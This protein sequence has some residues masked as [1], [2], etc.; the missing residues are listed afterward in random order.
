M[1]S[2]K[3]LTASIVV[4]GIIFSIPIAIAQTAPAP[5]GGRGPI[6]DQEVYHPPEAF[7]LKAD[8]KAQED[9]T[10]QGTITF[11]NRGEEILGDM[12]YLIELLGELPAATSEDPVV[13][14]NAPVYDTVTS[15][16]R[17]A[18][19]GDEQKT[20]PYTYTPP[21]NLPSGNYRIEI[22][23]SN[24]RGRTLGWYDVP[25]TLTNEKGSFAKLFPG[26]IS[27]AE[28]GTQ[29]FGAESGPNV[30][31]GKNITITGSA[32]SLTTKSVVPELTIHAFSP[33]RPLLRTVKGS[34]MSLGTEDR[35]FSLSVP[36]SQE[37]G[38]YIGILSL[39]DVATNEP[40]SNLTT[41]R[42]VVRGQ[43][44]DILHVRMKS[45][46]YAQNDTMSF[47]IDHVGAA[48][49]ETKTTGKISMELRDDEG[50]LGTLT[51]P[52]AELDDRI[53][54]GEANFTLGR[55]LSGQAVLD[56]KVTKND[57]YPLTSY[58][59]RYPFTS[60]QLKTLE[61]S[62]IFSHILLYAGAAIALV[63][64]ITLAKAS[65]SKKRQTRRK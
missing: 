3:P 43:A 24:G 9:G 1:F 57:G 44:A 25:V 21:K 48:D 16:E 50:V 17:F 65:Q 34:R 33:I 15:K 32:S 60:E 2:Y 56:I 6:Q 40:V 5:F 59:V 11:W 28:Y 58:T 62:K 52:S 39:K 31:P 7:V 49:A 36:T 41:Y 47:A 12:T 51:D 29:T 22:T 8:G 61:S 63:G 53:L 35:S 64:A 54:T 45:Y 55:P 14:D 13:D 4:A 46:A 19:I 26:D 27:I 37:P 30:T 10:V 20:I 42:W 23:I 18:L 38:V